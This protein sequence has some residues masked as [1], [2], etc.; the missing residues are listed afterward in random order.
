MKHVMT[1]RPVGITEE[2]ALEWQGIYQV[3]NGSFVILSPFI[4]MLKKIVFIKWKE[5]VLHFLGKR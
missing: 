3:S 2:V 1:Q 5:T 4:S